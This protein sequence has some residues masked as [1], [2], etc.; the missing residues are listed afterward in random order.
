MPSIEM[1]PVSRMPC[2]KVRAVIGLLWLVGMVVLVGRTGACIV[3]GFQSTGAISDSRFP[4]D[5]HWPLLGS[6]LDYDQTWGFHWPGWPLLRSLLLPVAAW[7]PYVEFVIL[8]SFWLAAAWLLSEIVKSTGQT[9]LSW[10]V[11]AL[12]L[13]APGYLVSLQ[14]YRPEII[15]GFALVVCLWSW[16][17]HG[18]Y[19]KVLKGAALVLLPLLHPVGF[20]LPVVWIGSEC[21]LQWRHAGFSSACKKS[22]GPGLCLLAGIL[23]FVA[24]YAR[25]PATWLQFQTNLKTQRLLAQGLGPGYWSVLRW[26]YGFKGALPLILILGGAVL[27]SIVVLHQQLRTKSRSGA[28]T[29]EMM[30]ALAFLAALAFN[31]IT[32]NPNT[33]HLLAVAP[34]AAWLYVSAVNTVLPAS[35]LTLRAC[36]LT[37]TL[38]VCNVLPLK[39][40]YLL[41]KNRGASYRG[42]LHAALSQLPPEAKVLIPV[43]FW[44][45]AVLLE[46]AEPGLRYAFSTFPN[47]LEK[48]PRV[49]YEKAALAELQPGDLV[50]WDPLLDEAGIFNFVEVTALRHQIIRPPS[51]P[52]TWEKV[53]DIHIAARYSQSQSVDFE[54][55]RKR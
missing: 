51:Q 43:A 30:V 39:N 54:L 6:F 32:K 24:W 46:K 19:A 7:H 4:G 44:E 33:N 27:G 20:V 2:G 41:C 12:S 26:G 22:L 29:P 9:I 49:T 15:T 5:L 48:E 11:F 40:S 25:D 53:K 50:I 1:P 45:S 38:L 28:T 8:C 31:L 37:A 35:V 23:V 47:I 52:E 13:L 16:H 14:S 3:D 34:F 55:Y 42:D 36:A 21:L 17:G 10:W 18:T